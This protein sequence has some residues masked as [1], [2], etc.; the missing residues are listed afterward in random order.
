[1]P[2]V[3]T[4][5]QMPTPTDAT[6][7]R[8]LLIVED[9]PTMAELLR[10][11]LASESYEIWVA[12][13]AA[14]AATITPAYD[15]D[16]TIVD[17]DLARG[18]NGVDLAFILTRQHPGIAILLLTHHHDLRSVGFEPGDLPENCGFLRKDAV[19]SKAEILNA[20]DALV[21]SAVDD[22]RQDVDPARPFSDLN[23]TQIEVLRMVA[24]G[25]TNQE[26]ASRRTTSIRAVE[27]VI[28][29][30]FLALGIDPAN[31]I[32]PR[33]AAARHFVSA[34]GTPHRI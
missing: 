6:M 14:E 22:I 21:G 31:G 1:L 7:T 32:N 18:A 29:A 2:R 9:E 5:W 28:N 19:M 24:Q 20:I 8:R 15:P 3:Q 34:S 11:T 30:V 13:S 4:D 25:Y 33:V 17:V 12:H 26:I 23:Q 16:I 10:D 27:Q